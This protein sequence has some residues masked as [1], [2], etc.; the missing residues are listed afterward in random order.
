M[1]EQ[2]KEVLLKQDEFKDKDI[3]V[4]IPI[5]TLVYEEKLKEWETGIVMPVKV[6]YQYETK[7]DNKKTKKIETSI[8]AEYCPFCGKRIRDME[9]IKNENN[10]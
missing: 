4:T 10:K 3:K 1:E 2:A 5:K 9:E 7:T 8:L 6:Q